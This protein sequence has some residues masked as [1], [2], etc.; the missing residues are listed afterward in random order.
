MSKFIAEIEHEVNEIPCI[1]AVT[2]YEP[3]VPAFISGPPEDC[4]TDE[5]GYSEWEIKKVTGQDYP[6]LEKQ[7]TLKDVDFINEVVFRHFE[8]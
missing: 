1:I 8:D 3:Y 7:L 5:G 6:W 2:H 4:Y